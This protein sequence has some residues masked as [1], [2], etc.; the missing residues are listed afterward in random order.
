M[1][2]QLLSISFLQLL[3]LSCLFLSQTPT[4]CGQNQVTLLQENFDGGSLPDGWMEKTIINLQSNEWTVGTS[5]TI[6]TTN[7]A[8]VTYNLAAGTDMYDG[9][10]EDDNSSNIILFTP[11]INASNATNVTVNFTW[12]AAGESDAA[13]RDYLDYGTIVYSLNNGETFTPL[14]VK[15]GGAITGTGSVIIPPDTDD[16]SMAISE[17][18][19][20]QFRIGFQ[21]IND[22]LVSGLASFAIDDLVI[23]GE[24]NNDPL[25][26]ELL[27]FQAR[28]INQQQIQLSWQ[29]TNEIQNTGFNV[30]RSLNGQGFQKIGFVP[31]NENGNAINEYRYQD[32]DLR[33]GRHYY[34]LQSV[35]SNGNTNLSKIVSMTTNQTG[36]VFKVYPNQVTFHFTIEFARNLTSTTILQLLSIT[37]QSIRT[38]PVAAGALRQEIDISSLNL[39]AGTYV[40]QLEQDGVIAHQKIIKE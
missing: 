38:I 6:N 27:D 5:T 36:E 20:Q 37:G 4:V 17:L 9:T 7:A 34:R 19:G 32:N 10:S 24:M 33:K 15:F 11:E 39:P 29:T 28:I 14:D 13:V 22:Q 8:I 12:G 16:F 3:L 26:V 18:D 1:K 23:T 31:A 30:L 21:W 25:A 2:Y 35:E 40:L